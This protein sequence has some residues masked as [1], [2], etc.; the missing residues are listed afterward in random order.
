VSVSGGQN[1]GDTQTVRQ[2][3]DDMERRAAAPKLVVLVLSCIVGAA[4]CRD[5]GLADRNLPLEEAQHREY[6]YAV[7][8]SAANNPA[9]AM[10]G[11][12]W[13]RSLPVETVPARMLAPVG[14]A[15]GTPLY[16]LRG[17]S[18]PYSRLYAPVSEDRW[19]PHVRLN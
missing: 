19:L 10:G 17:Q 5:N 18:A 2:S 4:G 9:L 7:Y 13:V 16:A 12:H 3:E 6:G 11:R 1:N 14:N 8:Q 15:E